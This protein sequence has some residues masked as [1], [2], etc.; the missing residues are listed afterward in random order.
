MKPTMF[1]VM[2]NMRFPDLRS[3]YHTL[4]EQGHVVKAYSP[5][6]LGQ[7]VPDTTGWVLGSVGFKLFGT[8]VLAFANGKVKFSGG[9]VGYPQTADH[10]LMTWLLE[11]RIRPICDE[12]RCECPD[13][14]RL[15]LIN[16]F[17]RLERVGLENFH[18]TIDS[19]KN[20]FVVTPPTMYDDPSKRGRIC[21]VG[22]R[23][24]GIRGSMRFDH[25]G[26]M[27]LFGFKA[28]TEMEEAIRCLERHL[29][30]L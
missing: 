20:H 28:Y 29:K 7:V 11:H 4:V 27:Q 6:S 5:G 19:L 22:V 21:S 26:K 13:D 12:L 15:V 24:H 18:A 17:H 10:D 16:G 2:A 30:N 3:L 23:V 14:Y 9:C 1:V 8:S 25:T